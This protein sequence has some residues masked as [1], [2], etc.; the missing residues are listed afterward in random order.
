MND[1]NGL[2]LPETPGVTPQPT[3]QQ[4]Q[5]T[6][7]PNQQQTIINPTV[8]NSKEEP[9]PL[10]NPNLDVK[11]EQG[12]TE[13]IPN[14]APIITPNNQTPQPEQPMDAD[15]FFSNKKLIIIIGAVIIIVI[16]FLPTISQFFSK[17]FS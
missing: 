4:P 12:N 3:P 2:N 6:N 5:P 9:A 10:I 1:N 13:F 7:I 15:A 14:E 11:L 17:L 8:A 16:L